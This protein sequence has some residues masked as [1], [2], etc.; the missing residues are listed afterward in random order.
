M[1]EAFSD[2]WGGWRIVDVLG[3]PVLEL[4]DW[5]VHDLLTLRYIASAMREQRRKKQ[6]EAADKTVAAKKWS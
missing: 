5:L 2:G 1:L 6:S 3:K 4:P